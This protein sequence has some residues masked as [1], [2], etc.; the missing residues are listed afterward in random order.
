MDGNEGTGTTDAGAIFRSENMYLQRC[1]E[2]PAVRQDRS[3]I[4]HH[5]FVDHVHQFW[6]NSEKIQ[7][8]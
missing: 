7:S 2:S 5:L 6:E 3:G 1:R 8:L 4:S